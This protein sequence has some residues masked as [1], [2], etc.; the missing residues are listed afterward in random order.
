[1]EGTQVVGLSLYHSDHYP[2]ATSRDTT[3][4]SFLSEVGVSPRMVTEIVVVFRT[5]PVR[6]AGEQAGPLKDEITWE[7]LQKES[8]YPYG[9]SE[10][11]SVTRKM[12]RVGRF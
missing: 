7:Q 5:F 6:V 10:W 1:M 4:S 9:I 11:T 8:G 3:A 2:R 12:R